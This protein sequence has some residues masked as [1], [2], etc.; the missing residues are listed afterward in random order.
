MKLKC[1]SC[2]TITNWT[3]DVNDD[4]DDHDYCVKCDCILRHD[5]GDICCWCEERLDKE[6][7][8]DW[9]KMADKWESAN[10]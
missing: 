10:D 4:A 8:A 5:E 9:T 7:R 6:S 1:N 3:V 2:E